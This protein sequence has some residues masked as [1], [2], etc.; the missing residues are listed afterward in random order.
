MDDSLSVNSFLPEAVIINR[1]FA[2]VMPTW[3]SFMFWAAWVFEV[4]NW[5]RLMKMT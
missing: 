4:S 2:R 5:P 1:F 3:R